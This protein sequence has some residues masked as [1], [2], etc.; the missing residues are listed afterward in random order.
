MS[1]KPASGFPYEI[2]PLDTADHNRSC[3]SC[4][5]NSLDRYLKK[6]ANQDLKRKVN[7]TYVLV[8]KGCPDIIGYYNLSHLSIEYDSLP[9]NTKT[10]LPAYGEIPATLIGRLA[11]DKEYQGKGLGEHILLDALRKTYE[12]TQQIGSFSVVVDLQEEDVRGFYRKYEF[13][14]LSDDKDR[15][16]VPMK[17][18]ENLLDGMKLL[19][20]A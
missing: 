10:N 14:S 5:N 20:E 9:A 7:V 12:I 16:F 19:P 17:K 11:V 13:R 4:G 3:F 8:K 2:E 18:V 1:S 15:L 6:Q